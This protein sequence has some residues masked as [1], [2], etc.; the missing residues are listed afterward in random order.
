MIARL[1][2]AKSAWDANNNSL[3]LMSYVDVLRTVLNFSTEE[4]KQTIKSQM[5]E[6]KIMWRL[7]QLRENGVYIDPELDQKLAI[8]KGLTGESNSENQPKGFDA[9]EFEGESLTETVKRKIDEELGDLIKPTEGK[10]SIQQVN[11]FE[12]HGEMFKSAMQTKKDLG[13][14]F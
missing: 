4:I 8:M 3:N 10:A 9:L 11:L 5:I 1:D 7:Q 14:D 2:L 13:T 12:D 6:K